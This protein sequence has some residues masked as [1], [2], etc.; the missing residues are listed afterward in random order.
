MNDLF[1]LIIIVR[2]QTGPVLMLSVISALQ[3]VPIFVD[4][5]WLL[6]V[7]VETEVDPHTA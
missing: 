6:L 2:Y 3:H 1:P 7:S 5:T 4:R